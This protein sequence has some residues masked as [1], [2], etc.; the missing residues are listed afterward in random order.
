MFLHKYRN[1]N[2]IT[3]SRAQQTLKF[4]RY[5]GVVHN[6]LDFK[7]YVPSKGPG[8]YLVWLGR[9]VHDKGTWEAIQTAKTAKLPIVLAGKVDRFEP[10]S[11]EYFEKRVKK[12]IDGRQVKY[13]GEVN[14]QQKRKL[15]KDAIA[16]LHPINWNEPFGLVTIEAMAMGV[17]V[18]AFDRGPVRE[19]II[20]GKTGF[21]VKDIRQMATAVKKVSGLDR[22]FI[23]QYA[24]KNFSSAKMA[25]GYEKIY[26]NILNQ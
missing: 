10:L 20:P 4:L 9:M 1:K 17:P 7:S 24:L 3:I 12:H 21:I 26:K 16:L 25:E 2:F 19:Q 15:L 14:Q 13:I 11:F 8:K 6:G 5:V 22:T 18:V 23:H